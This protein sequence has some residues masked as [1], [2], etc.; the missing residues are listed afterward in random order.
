MLKRHEGFRNF[1]YEDTVGKLTIGFG[2]NL[3]DV[4]ISKK[5]AE[6]LLINDINK[7]IEDLISVL[8]ESTTYGNSRFNALAD[9]MFNLGKTKFR[10]FKKM[11]AAL[12]SRDFKK[13]AEEMMDSK[14]AKQVG[15]RA[16]ELARMVEADM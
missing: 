8:P 4:G 1:P 5:E 12:Q 6:I 9:M 16:K 3:E 14:W 2:R 13:A 7:A 15:Y 10:G 11:I